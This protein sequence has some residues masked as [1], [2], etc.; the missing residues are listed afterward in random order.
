MTVLELIELL[1]QYPSDLEV[2]KYETK[3]MGLCSVT[4]VVLISDIDPNV[5]D[6]VEIT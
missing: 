5:A 6:R 2:V 1:W 3:W 4:D